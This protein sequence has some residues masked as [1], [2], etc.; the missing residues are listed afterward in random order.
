MPSLDAI[1]AGP[2]VK[3]ILFMTSTNTVDSV[4]KPHWNAQ[5]LRKGF[6]ASVLQVVGRLKRTRRGE[7]THHWHIDDIF[8]QN[9]A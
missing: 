9:L 2:P 5:V 6:G 7:V 8:R 1:L 4:L 3:K